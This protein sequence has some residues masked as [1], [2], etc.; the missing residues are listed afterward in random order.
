MEEEALEDMGGAQAPGMAA[1]GRAHPAY[2][3]RDKRKRKVRRVNT[4][5]LYAA[6]PFADRNV[7][8]GLQHPAATR[9]VLVCCKPPHCCMAVIVV[10]LF[11]SMRAQAWDKE[12]AD[13]A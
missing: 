4:A 5:Q 6:S 12:S 1:A 8:C 11:R 9:C 13:G 10:S 3:G 2:A 7:V